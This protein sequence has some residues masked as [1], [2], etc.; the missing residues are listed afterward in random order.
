[1]EYFLDNIKNNKSI[2]EAI[3]LA[4]DAIGVITVP[5]DKEDGTEGFKTV[6]GLPIYY[7]GDLVQ[8]FCVG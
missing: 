4:N 5:Y 2:Q 8:Y 1:M 6:E 3:I 7:K